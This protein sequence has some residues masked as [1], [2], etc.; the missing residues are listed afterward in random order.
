MTRL[1]TLFALIA[2]ILLAAVGC[3]PATGDPTIADNFKGDH[4]GEVALDSSDIKG[5]QEVEGFAQSGLMTAEANATRGGFLLD[6][7][8]QAGDAD[9][10]IDVRGQLP[11]GSFTPWVPAEITWREA[12]LVVGR[13]DLPD[14]VTATQFRLPPEQAQLVEHMTY[15]G[16]ALDPEETADDSSGTT[17][18]ALSSQL[19][20]FVNSRASWKARSSSCSSNPSKYRMAIHHT[21]TPFSSSGGY[22]A[23][24]RGIQAYH[25]DT[26]G[27]CDIG[28]HF[29]VTEDGQ[30]WEGRPLDRLGAHV[31]NNNTGNVGISYVG[32][33]EPNAECQKMVGN[34]KPPQAMIEGGAQIVAEISKLYGIDISASTVKGHRD[35][36]GASTDCPG[37][38]LYARL[39]DIRALAKNPGSAPPINEPPGTEPPTATGVA[40]GVVWDLASSSSPA[41]GTRLDQATIAVDSGTPTKVRAG[42]AFWQL[43]LSV[44]SHTLTAAAP[45]YETATT[46]VD[47]VDGGETWASIGLNPTVTDVSVSVRALGSAGQPLPGA[48]VYL[49]SQGSAK[50]TGSDGRADFTAVPGSLAIQVFEKAHAK[51]SVTLSVGTQ[52]TQSVDV[53]LSAASTSGYSAALQGVVW[54]S[55][56]ASSAA[57]SSNARIPGAIIISSSGQATTARAGDAYWRIDTPP[58][59]YTFTV[60]APGFASTSFSKT[61]SSGVADWG[62]VGLTPAP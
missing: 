23:R 11:D 13:A 6:L 40:L 42:D 36:S 14:V 58:G 35:H 52:A 38:D 29:L 28:Y 3:A 24:I 48:I 17:Q 19:A 9:V 15:A 57:T 56:K 25:M 18:Q 41:N 62:S 8:Q 61:L 39:G 60:L 54:D 20:P 31:A 21:Y 30:V 44:G 2:I 4:G 46:T 53:K 5:F 12:P 34:T 16:I 27:W 43:K 33:F 50:V 55:S 1:R 49:P 7:M 26:R 37:E 59:S 32:C 22:A 47:V 51:K 45:G 10:T